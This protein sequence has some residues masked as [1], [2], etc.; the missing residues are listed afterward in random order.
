MSDAQTPAELAAKPWRLSPRFVRFVAVSALAAVVN[1]GARIVFSHWC[2]YPIAV[3]L[4]FPVGLVTAFL[5]NRRFVFRDASDPLH[6]QVL[7]FVLV[8]LAGLA[9]TLLVSV[10]LAHWL[11]ILGMG[12]HAED[13]AHAVGIVVP[14]VTSYFGHKWLS[15]R[16]ERD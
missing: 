2:P 16:S 4:A 6:R 3:A 11:F 14:T 7:W 1:F 15:F 5:L 12:P 8:N 13:V 10:V 9:Q